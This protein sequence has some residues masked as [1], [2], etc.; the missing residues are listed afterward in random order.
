VDLDADE[1]EPIILQ[2]VVEGVRYIDGA[3]D[4]EDEAAAVDANLQ[5]VAHEGG[6][7]LDVKAEDE[8]VQAAAVDA[9]DETEPGVTVSPDTVKGRED[10]V[11]VERHHVM[12]AA[13]VRR[14]GSRHLLVLSISIVFDHVENFLKLRFCFWISRASLGTETAL[15]VPPE[16]RLEI[17]REM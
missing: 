9:L 17:L 10:V 5:H 16:A 1:G 8:A 13:E 15:F 7:P 12:A 11:L 3:E 4:L 2:E 14:D 6:L